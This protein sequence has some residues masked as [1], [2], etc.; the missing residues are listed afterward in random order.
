MST[1]S[2]SAAA[3]RSALIRS[4]GELLDEGGVEAVTLRAVGARAGVSR[5]APYGHFADKDHLLTQLAIDAWVSLADRLEIIREAG[6]S[7]ESKLERALLA[8]IAIGRDQPHLYE[9]MFAAPA[10]D[11]EAALRAVAR[12]QEVFLEIVGGVV[13]DRD[14]RRYGA[15]LLSS[16]H[17]IAGMELSG[18]LAKDKWSVTGDE[19]VAMLVASVTGSS[20]RV[21][22]PSTRV[23]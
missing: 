1:R 9:V 10:G 17:G 5:G 19:L 23:P 4:A 13:G 18:H 21:S 16:A 3:T 11:P 12:S 14:G 8:L 15:L 6:V 7:P 22:S 2:E 20:P